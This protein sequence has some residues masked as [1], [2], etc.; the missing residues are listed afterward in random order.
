MRR[1]SCTSLRSSLICL[2]SSPLWN[3]KQT[4][5]TTFSESK[6]AKLRRSA[7]SK[8][9][10]LSARPS[11]KSSRNS[12][13]RMQLEEM[14]TMKSSTTGNYLKVPLPLTLLESPCLWRGPMSVSCLWW[15]ESQKLQWMV[16]QW[17]NLKFSTIQMTKLRIWNSQRQKIT[18]KECRLQPTSPR[19]VW[20]SVLWCW[21]V[22]KISRLVKSLKAL[23]FPFKQVLGVNW[24]FVQLLLI[25]TPRK[26]SSKSRSLQ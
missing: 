20:L 9:K 11:S 5:A 6:S 15:W 1:K 22:L 21:R 7:I 4:F 18:N 13:D 8:K 25:K 14:L 12:K 19:V 26:S 24:G 3:T 10:L 16:L 2:Q 17:L 23:K